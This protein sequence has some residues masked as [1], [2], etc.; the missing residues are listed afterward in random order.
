MTVKVIVAR[1]KKIVMIFG[2]KGRR[3]SNRF[4]LYDL[5]KNVISVADNKY[6]SVV[7]LYGM[8]WDHVHF[9]RHHL[10]R[11]INKFPFI[12]KILRKFVRVP[13]I[14]RGPVE[15]K[16]ETLA[17]YDFAICPENYNGQNGYITEKIWDAM[18]SGCIPI[19]SGPP[20]INQYIPKNCRIDFNDFDSIEDMFNFVLTMSKED[21]SEMKMRIYKYLKGPDVKEFDQKHFS[22]VLTQIIKLH[23]R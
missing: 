6:S 7:D 2:N 22:S 21:I 10:L 5:R 8:S 1:N 12:T 20:N 11:Y 16:Y 18:K 23:E 3:S 9:S 15:S 13:K 14:Y 19:Y 4:D 17:Q